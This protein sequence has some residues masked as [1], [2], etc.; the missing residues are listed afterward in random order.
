MIMKDKKS[1]KI[2]NNFIKFTTAA[3]VI[4][5]TSGCVKKPYREMPNAIN[6]L[7]PKLFLSMLLLNYPIR[8]TILYFVYTFYSKLY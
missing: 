7:L 5:T 8:M 2:T 1:M 3:A 6:L 4:A